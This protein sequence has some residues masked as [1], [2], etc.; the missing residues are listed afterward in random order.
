MDSWYPGMLLPGERHTSKRMDIVLNMSMCYLGL[1]RECYPPSDP[2]Q[3][4]LRR[5]ALP[6]HEKLCRISCNVVN[7]AQ[8]PHH[9]SP[10]RITPSSGP[11]PVHPLR[12]AAV[13]LVISAKPLPLPPS[14]FPVLAPPPL[15]VRPVAAWA[16]TS[17]HSQAPTLAH[18]ARWMLI[19]A[20]RP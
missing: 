16:Q 6:C 20:A 17:I 3:E 13:L 5:W 11:R 12:M 9:Q 7:S 19:A 4:L 14:S 10:L 15:R 18:V 2:L 1:G 8:A